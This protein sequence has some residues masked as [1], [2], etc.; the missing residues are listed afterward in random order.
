MPEKY[1][2]ALDDSGIT[3]SVEFGDSWTYA[4]MRQI[5]T[6]PDAALMEFLAS[7]MTAVSLPASDGVVISSAEEF[8]ARWQSMDVRLFHWLVAVSIKERGRI[9]SLGETMLREF[10]KSYV[11]AQTTTATPADPSK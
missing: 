1:S 10:L 9:G 6:L 3:G 8:L 2:I 11:E 5:D 7:K 4:E